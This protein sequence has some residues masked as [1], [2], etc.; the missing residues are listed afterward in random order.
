MAADAQ[1]V[2]LERLLRSASTDVQ[3][4]RIMASLSD[5]DSAATPVARTSRN[6]FRDCRS[7]SESEDEGTPS[8][9]STPRSRAGSLD[10]EDLLRSAGRVLDQPDT[11]VGRGGGGG[12][13]GVAKAGAADAHPLPAHVDEAVTL[14]ERRKMRPASARN[15]SNSVSMTSLKAI[16]ENGVM[17][18]P[19]SSKKGGAGPK[20]TAAAAP[21]RNPVPRRWTTSGSA[22]AAENGWHGGAG[23]H[24]ETKGDVVELN[25]DEHIV[26]VHASSHDPARPVDRVFNSGRGDDFWVTTGGF[27]QMIHAAFCAP[28]WVTK[29]S[30]QAAGV[31]ALA[32]SRTSIAPAGAGAGRAADDSLAVLASHNPTGM[33]P[34]G[35]DAGEEPGLGLCHFSIQV[36]GN[37]QLGGRPTRHL[38]IT[39]QRGRDAFCVVREV[40][41][42]GVMAPSEDVAT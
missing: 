15:R 2:E 41:I 19:L 35:Q 9:S 14:Q 1:R 13:G 38:V 11:P 5:L 4:R 20:K 21:V 7:E 30:V 40:R 3:R 8:S 16:P 28:V 27:P 10:E 17:I 37:D 22:K 23:A 25:T 24:G 18:R 26:E 29:I 6:G 39:L 32:V 42:W 31:L 34:I 33:T 36:A 12:V